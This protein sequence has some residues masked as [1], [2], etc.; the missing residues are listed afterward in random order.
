MLFTISL[1]H[2]LMLLSR[3]T[4][5]KAFS[6]FNCSVMPCACFITLYESFKAYL[7]LLSYLWKQKTPGSSHGE[8]R[9]T[10][11]MGFPSDAFSDFLLG[12]AANRRCGLYSDIFI[13]NSPCSTHFLNWNFLY[14]NIL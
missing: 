2:A 8:G 14:R 5:S 6:A 10:V 1:A 4:H 13:F 3:P 12:C 7:C 9:R 11:P